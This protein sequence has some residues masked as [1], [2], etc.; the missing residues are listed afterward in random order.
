MLAVGHSHK[1]KKPK[2]GEH[3]LKASLSL[4]HLVNKSMA[5]KVQPSVFPLK[6][7]EKEAQE[8]RDHANVLQRS[9]N[10]WLEAVQKSSLSNAV[11]WTKE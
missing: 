2:P 11:S 6:V 3:F 9:K 5:M 8:Q 1:K 10:C 4:V 7:T